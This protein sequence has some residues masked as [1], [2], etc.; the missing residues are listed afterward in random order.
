MAASEVVKRNTSGMQ[1]IKTLQILL[2]NDF[3]MIELIEK[4]NENEKEPIFNNS[5]ISKYINTCRFCG[6]DIPKIH[7]RYFLAKLPFG[8]NLTAND[9]KLLDMLQDFANKKL[10]G[11]SNKLFNSFITRLN[12]YSNKDIIRV[13]KNTF[14]LTCE[15]FD[16]AVQ[17]K[18]KIRLMFKAQALLECIPLAITEQRG[19]LCFKILHDN[20]ER[21]ISMERVSGLQI[22]GKIYIPPEEELGETVI[23]K[24]KGELIPR[25][26]MREY[27]TEIS[28]KLPDEITISN[29]GEDKDEL[30]ARLLRYDKLC[31]IVSPQSYRNELKAML[32]KMLENYEEQNAFIN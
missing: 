4:L 32:N 27:E 16:K 29:T 31:E 21:Y 30:L 5:V 14:N 18:R 24:I 11:K 17:E 12:K 9:F 25:Y 10:N 26:T 1:V 15:T 3:S 28:R 2:E 6:F 13:E 20:K 23:F 22:L 19:K 7:N 8:L